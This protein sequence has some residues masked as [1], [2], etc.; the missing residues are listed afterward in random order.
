MKKIKHGGYIMDI[1]L[2]IFGATIYIVITEDPDNFV[3]KT[4]LRE[5]ASEDPEEILK[6]YT[7]AMC[8]QKRKSEYYILL[9]PCCGIEQ[10]AHESIHCIGRLFRDRGIR[11]DYFNDETFAYYVGWIT[12]SVYDHLQESKECIKANENKKT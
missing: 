12:N 6:K 8:F 4:G 10:C 5:W 11:A 1:A 3:D 2:N 7:D 9:S